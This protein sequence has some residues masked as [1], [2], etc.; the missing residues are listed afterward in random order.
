MGERA[1]P[2]GPAPSN[3]PVDAGGAQAAAPGRSSGAP[4]RVMLLAFT[5]RLPERVRNY[6]LNLL[7]EGVEVDLAILGTDA[8]SEHEP[9]Q[10]AEVSRHPR[11][12]VH[13]LDGAE[14]R[15]PVR[16]VERLLVYKLPGGAVAG[17]KRLT[18]R[19][20]RSGDGGQPEEGQQRIAD[21]IH[22]RVFMPF[23]RLG[24]PRLLAR[25]FH[26]R[27]AGVDFTDVDRVVAA[28]VYAVTFGW[29]LARRYPH[30]VATMQ[31]DLNLHESHRSAG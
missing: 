28:D 2:V 25:M 6:V 12:R 14:H 8:W 5:H 11:L 17:T 9:E 27:L 21:A 29:Q 26:K 20:Q 13:S 7:A 1:E 19:G 24:R 23:Y 4:V 16:R 30:L 31:L 10:W 3:G 15:H 18:G 22:N